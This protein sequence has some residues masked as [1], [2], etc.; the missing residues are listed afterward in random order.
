MHFQIINFKQ[1][2]QIVI[3]HYI[4]I[5]L[6]ILMELL[7]FKDIKVNSKLN[8]HI[9]SFIIQQFNDLEFIVKNLLEK[10]VTKFKDK[11][12]NEFKEE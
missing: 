10:V 1:I 3:C 5:L 8:L 9:R 7:H 6:I 2:F 4:V 12:V 11:K